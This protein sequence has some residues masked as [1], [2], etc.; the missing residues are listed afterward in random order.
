LVPVSITVQAP[1]GIPAA[2][3]GLVST[4]VSKTQINLM[5][6][7]NSANEDGFKIERS[8]N[9][10]SWTQIGTV[11]PNVTSYASTGLTANKIYYYRVRAHNIL[12]NSGYS[13][14]ASAKTLK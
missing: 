10:S 5:W 8:A 7:D 6:N 14:T 1:T 3:S 2:P 9:G 4:A 13:N 12:G 11:G